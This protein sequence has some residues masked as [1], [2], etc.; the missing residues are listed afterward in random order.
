V[1][2]LTIHLTLYEANGNYYDGPWVND[3]KHGRGTFFYVD[4][5]Q[6]YEGEWES[7][8]PVSGNLVPMT[9]DTKIPP[10]GLANPDAVVQLSAKVDF[11]VEL[12]Q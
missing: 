5:Q 2:T 3:A 4:K 7:G 1:V 6:K 10:I 11:K 12:V 9:A 8:I